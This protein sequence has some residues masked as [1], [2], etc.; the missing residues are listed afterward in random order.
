MLS[1]S[2]LVWPYKGQFRLSSLP[3]KQVVDYI[4]TRSLYA[5]PLR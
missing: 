1:V 3:N 2:N 4:V 5:L